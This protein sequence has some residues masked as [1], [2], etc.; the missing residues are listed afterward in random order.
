MLLRVTRMSRPHRVRGIEGS[1]GSKLQCPCLTFLQ[2]SQ[3]MAVLAQHKLA[4]HF[5]SAGRG[6]CAC[7]RTASYQDT[8]YD[9]LR[10]LFQ[11]WCQPASAALGFCLEVSLD[12]RYRIFQPC[13][14]LPKINSAPPLAAQAAT[15]MPG[16][17]A[18][19]PPD[20]NSLSGTAAGNKRSAQADASGSRLPKVSKQAALIARQKASPNS[21]L[22]PPQLGGR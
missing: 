4:L 15:Q 16:S 13:R 10:K 11:W 9:R 17:A 8:S 12:H 7:F 18:L 5:Q 19:P 2:M 1:T 22:R 20:L 3:V 14:S 21:F 6:L